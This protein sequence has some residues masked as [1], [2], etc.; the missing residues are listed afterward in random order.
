MS[1]SSLSELSGEAVLERDAAGVAST[2]LVAKKGSSCTGDF[3]AV[4]D[5]IM[6]FKPKAVA[7]LFST[8]SAITASAANAVAAGLMVEVAM[9][10]NGLELGRNFG[11]ETGIRGYCCFDMF[12]VQVRPP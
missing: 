11:G 9:A 10:D 8:E 2:P 12:C 6:F 7:E 3:L 1:S 4:D 5:E